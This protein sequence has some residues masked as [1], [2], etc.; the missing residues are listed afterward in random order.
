MQVA[1]GAVVNFLKR[2]KASAAST[3]PVLRLFHVPLT[4]PLQKRDRVLLLANMWLGAMC[5]R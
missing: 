4:A 3:H 5:T 2:V 1:A